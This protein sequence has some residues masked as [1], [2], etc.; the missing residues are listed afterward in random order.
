MEFQSTQLLFVIPIEIIIGS[1]G[2]LNI[3][4]LMTLKEVTKKLTLVET[5]GA[6]SVAS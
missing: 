1:T 5:D 4:N 6:T 3:I 2:V